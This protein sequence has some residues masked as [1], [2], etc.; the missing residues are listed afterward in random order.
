LVRRFGVIAGSGL[1][2]I[3][4]AEQLHHN[5]NMPLVIG[6]AG[7]AEPALKAF[8]YVDLPLEKI[9]YAFPLLKSHGA[10]HVV[11]AGGVRRRP[12][13]RSLR[14]PFA[15]WPELPVALFALKRGDDGLLGTIVKM[16]ERQG[17][18][19]VG[20]HEILP[21][22]IAPFGVLTG[23]MPA[24]SFHETIRMG[25]GVASTIGRYD[26]GQAVIAL[27]RRVIAIEGIEGTDQMLSRITSLRAEGR[28]DAHAKPILIKLAKPGQELRADMPVIGPTTI[29]LCSAAGIKLICLSAGSTM[30]MDVGSTVAQAKMAGISVIG[31]DPAE[32]NEATP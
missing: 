9:A 29:E 31:I 4:L 12:K 11:F 13:I 30:V 14:V 24:L 28:I 20:A 10:T 1:L 7:E 18:S 21:D 22:Q 3:T 19:V 26:I 17:I 5:G 6:I 2:P 25:V 32:W 23:S 15:L 16:F 27:G 8:D